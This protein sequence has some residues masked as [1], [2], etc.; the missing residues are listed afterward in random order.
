[1]K[2]Q[3]KLSLKKVNIAPINYLLAIKG[4]LGDNT[5][6]CN[7]ENGC[8][9][10]HTAANNTCVASIDYVETCKIC[11]TGTTRGAGSI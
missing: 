5:R 7:G 3:R 8:V 9:S 2:K 1:M 10:E 11:K 4:G 6:T